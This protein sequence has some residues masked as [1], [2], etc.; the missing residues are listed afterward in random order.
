MAEQGATFGRS[1]RLVESE[2][3]ATALRK[4]PVARGEFV[5]LHMSPDLAGSARLGL[6]VPK[7]FLRRATSRNATKRALR[8]TF[9]LQRYDLKSGKYVFRLTKTPQ[10]LSLKKLKLLIRTD[11]EHL[12][13]QCRLLPQRRQS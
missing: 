11:A 12:I 7:R 13:A 2:D 8:E 4:K 5:S 10:A 6:I 3:F 1:A 9:R